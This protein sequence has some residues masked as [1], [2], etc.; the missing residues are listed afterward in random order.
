MK[1]TIL[2]T[3]K[4]IED[5]HQVKILYACESGS[6][7]WGYSSK[8]SDY[9]VRFIY[10]HTIEEYLTIDP[11]GIGKKRDVIELPINDLLDVSGWELSK[12][13]RLFR[14]SNPPL[15]EWLWSGLVYYQAFSSIE[16]MKELSKAIFA[17]H[18]CL[19]H[20]LNMADKNFR[21]YLQT[22][23]V[24]IKQYFNVLRPFLAASWI[25]KFNEFPP[26][27]FPALLEELVSEGERKKEIQILLKRKSAGEGLKLI[28]PIPELND[29]L[30]EEMDRIREYAKSLH[31]S[32]PDST[33]QLDLLFRNTLKE[34]WR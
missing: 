7:A 17:P 24:L 22:D 21:D 25:E 34:V 16:K 8:E 32:L 26:L 33:P 30:Q 2:T 5:E 3:L 14:K 19:Y 11:V 23:T 1:E 20:Y 10:V 12:A 28:T 15:L 29:F 27:E 18:S 13:L 4:K 6:R 31:I 9:D